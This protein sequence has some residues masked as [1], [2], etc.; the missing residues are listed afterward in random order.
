MYVAQSKAPK[1]QLMVDTK[2]TIRNWSS[3]SELA[4]REKLWLF[5][6]P[7]HLWCCIVKKVITLPDI[8]VN[9]LCF[10]YGIW[11][12]LFCIFVQ[13]RFQY[14][15]E[16]VSG[17]IIP[18]AVIIMCYV[19]ILRRLR[20]TKFQRKVHSEKLILAIVVTFGIFWLPY[21]VINML[22][23]WRV[24]FSA[25]FSEISNSAFTQKRNFERCL[26][27]PFSFF[28]GGEVAAEWYA[29]DSPTREM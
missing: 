29:E 16:T 1:Q 22:Q 4:I 12:D 28:G 25:C 27:V 7:C 24:L 20:Q 2:Q 23:V 5:I 26:L 9:S 3:C 13:V 14:T 18:Y 10:S 21:H 8:L 15:F 19:L 6:F 11:K 17:F